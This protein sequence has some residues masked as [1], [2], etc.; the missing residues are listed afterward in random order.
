MTAPEPSRTDLVG[1][2][3]TTG[4][5]DLLDAYE[6]LR[7]LAADDSLPPCVVANVRHALAAVAQAVN[8]LALDFEHLLDVGV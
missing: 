3:L 6:R 2:E 5:A 8:D 7:G 4:E 1:R